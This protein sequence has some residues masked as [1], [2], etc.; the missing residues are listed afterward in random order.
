MSAFSSDDEDDYTYYETFPDGDDKVKRAING[1]LKKDTSNT[2]YDA[3]DVKWLM[4]QNG[5]FS[6]LELSETKDAC[7]AME[8]LIVQSLK[9]RNISA[10]A[11][12][13]EAEYFV[14]NAM[15]A[16]PPS[17]EV[18]NQT[19]VTMDVFSSTA[20]TAVTA[21]A[22][23]TAQMEAAYKKA[24]KSMKNTATGVRITGNTTNLEKLASGS[25]TKKIVVPHT[26]YTLTVFRAPA[27]EV[28]E[29]QVNK[30]A[31][32]LRLEAEIIQTAEK[33]LEPKE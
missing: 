18:R 30:R 5:E 15:T 17:K 1:L 20:A 26:T 33:V 24:W 32:R 19:I 31:K 14:R 11:I 10:V 23:L 6:D 8:K 27:S 16:K 29:E 7:S 21:L 22:D 9:Q 12:Q 28:S 4:S 13:F 2:F 3:W 25:D